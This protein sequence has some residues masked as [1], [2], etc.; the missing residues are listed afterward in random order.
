MKKL[1]LILAVVC[2][3]FIGTFTV[4]AQNTICNR[5]Y[6]L[7]TPG[8][9][10]APDSIDCIVRNEWTD[11][12]V[13]FV[14]FDSATVTGGIRVRVNYIIIDSIL[15]LPCGIKWSTSNSHYND[16]TKHRFDNK[17]KGCIRFWGVTNDNAGQYKLSIKVRARVS[18]FPN[19]DVPYTAEALGFR[20]DIRVKD[21]AAAVCNP[22]DTTAGANLSTA[23][24]KSLDKDTIFGDL[25]SISNIAGVSY[26]SFYPNPT[27]NTATVSFSADKASNYTARIINVYGAEVSREVLNVTTG[28]NVNKVDVSNL[29]NG[30]YIYT[31]TDGK[32]VQTQ[33]FVVEK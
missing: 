26:F 17:E 31:I 29:A 32:N 24:C 20:V 12:V 5:D 1:N 7:T 18:L 19:S 28:L 10:P 16:T 23:T 30:V 4:S 14:N 33:R 11:I 21:N 9:Y 25:T 15:N 13:Q 27:T 22:I 2:T 6:S 8:L 3:L